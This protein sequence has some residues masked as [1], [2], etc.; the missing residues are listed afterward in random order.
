MIPMIPMISVMLWYLWCYDTYDTCDNHDNYDNYATMILEDKYSMT[1]SKSRQ[2][3]AQM[4]KQNAKR[5]CKF[6]VLD[7]RIWIT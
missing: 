5:K 1:V 2:K 3:R 6:G 7:S 4:Q